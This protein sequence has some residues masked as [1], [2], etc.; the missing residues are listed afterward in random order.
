MH[1][2]EIE[3]M[4]LPN[5]LQR[6]RA[7]EQLMGGNASAM[8][9][10]SRPDDVQFIRWITKEKNVHKVKIG[11]ITTGL[12]T[13]AQA[14]EVISRGLLWK[15]ERYCVKQGPYRKLIQ[16]ESCQDFG[17]TAEDCSSAPRFQAC[18]GGHQTNDCPLGLTANSKSLN[19]RFMRRS[20]PCPRLILRSKT[21]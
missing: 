21:E 9:Y 6:I 4:K 18:A 3:S 11:S 20:S 7:I 19:V 8:Q 10:L 16:C 14:N 15:G 13:A 12:A 17:H 5:N 2:L 1:K